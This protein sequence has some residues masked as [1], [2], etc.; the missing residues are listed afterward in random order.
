MHCIIPVN[1]RVINFD[2]GLSCADSTAAES[3]TC[4][5]PTE[6]CESLQDTVLE[7]NF[8]QIFGSFVLLCGSAVRNNDVLFTALHGIAFTLCTKL[9][10]GL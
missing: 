6:P 8:S 7:N 5:A 4:H 1:Y 3:N 10:L 2:E 9:N